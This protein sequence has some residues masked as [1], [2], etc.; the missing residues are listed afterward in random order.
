MVKVMRQ[1]GEPAVNAGM[2]AELCRMSPSTIDRVLGPYRQLDGRHPLS[3]TKPGSLLKSS[4]P[5]RTFADWQE[6]RPGFLEVEPGGPLRRQQRGL[7]PYHPVGSG[8]RQR[9]VGMSPGL[10]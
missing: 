3:T 8:C 5:I 9:L 10:G 1:H 7:L 6:N 4:I 2:E